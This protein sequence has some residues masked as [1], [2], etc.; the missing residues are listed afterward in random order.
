MIK[1]YIHLYQLHSKGFFAK[2]LMVKIYHKKTNK[3]LKDELP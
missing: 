3:E 1:V 2:T